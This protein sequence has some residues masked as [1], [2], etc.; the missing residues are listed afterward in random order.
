M[1][2]RMILAKDLRYGDIIL[3]EQNIAVEI[4]AIDLRPDNKVL[5]YLWS[6]GKTLESDIGKSYG[7]VFR[8][9]QP[10]SIIDGR[11]EELEKRLS[12]CSEAVVGT[13]A[14]RQAGK[15]RIPLAIIVSRLRTLQAIIDLCLSE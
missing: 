11:L 3:D 6:D 4:C 5:L 15:D 10:D 14:M 2:A 9:P 1:A 12:A 8:R 13:R 7:V